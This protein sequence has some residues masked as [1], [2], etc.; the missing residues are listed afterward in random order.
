L[1]QRDGDVV[2]LDGISP[3]R[4]T[5]P[6]G[7]YHVAVRHR[8]HLAA[9]TNSP[10]ALNRIPAT[11]DL[12]APLTPTWGS[13]ARKLVGNTMLLWSGNTVLDNSVKYTGSQ[14]D[15]DPILVNVGSTTPNN[16]VPGYHRDD[17]NLDG[18]VKYTG[19]GNDRDGILVNVGS[20][21]PNNQRVEQL[22]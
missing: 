8:N 18:I 12:R 11:I 15:R 9:M 14:N 17:T 13:E 2:D 21:T 1:V 10:V 4:M 6:I 20:T 22:P 7:N 19:S 16:S 3:L 5:M